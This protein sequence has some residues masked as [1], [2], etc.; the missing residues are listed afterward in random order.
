MTTRAAI[1]REKLRRW[2]ASAPIFVRECIGAT[3]DAWQ[4]EALTA[5]STSPRLAMKA[6]KGP[7]KTAVLA[8]I[9]LWFL[10]TRPLAKIGATSITGENLHDN[11][12]AELAKWRMDSPMLR[13]TTTW[14]A[15]RVSVNDAPEQWF[16][17]AR[18]WPKHADAQR[19]AE[20]L[21]GLHADHVMFA[22]DESGSIPQAVMTTAEAV[23]ASGKEAKLVQAGNTTTLD[24]PLYRACVT[25]RA[26]WA[27][28]S[29]NGDPDDPNRSPR[30]S[31]EWA[32]QQIES[33]GRDNPW[34]MVNV[35]GQFPPASL[36]AL[37][38]PEDVETAFAR[39][40]RDEV[41]NWAQR[42]IGVDVARFGDDRTVLFPR[43]GLR[44]FR[45]RVLRH[46]RGSAVSTEIAGAVFA[47]KNRFGSELE[48]MDCTGGWAAGARDVLL[49]S[50]VPVIELEFGGKALDPRYENRRAELWF[51]MAEW[52]K[53]GGWL[54][55]VPEL[56]GE[57]TA[58]TYT[59]SRRG[60]FLIEPKELVKA[61]IGR[62]PDL[63]DGL[64]TTFGMPERPRDAVGRMG[65]AG[66]ALTADRAAGWE[67]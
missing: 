49:T 37:L 63:A 64:A 47:G 58:P 3:P 28:V 66:R 41:Y 59:F 32:R 8:W 2:A 13:A 45:P 43:Q 21:A 56:V 16:A 65:T 15:T 48:L 42:R 6:S 31:I 57:L 35:L 10:T 22:L 7:G 44:A 39:R 9:I 60:K 61:R 52:V 26:H 17:T 23:Q 27:V 20:T 12:W 11:L 1:A 33:Y 18:T 67:E 24:G 62:S 55:K 19:Q 4:D 51:Q 34:V 29:I 25:D 46:A 38:G 30:V 40:L 5:I 53:G 54:P 36:N 14:T 50:G